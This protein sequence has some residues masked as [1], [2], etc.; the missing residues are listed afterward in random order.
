[1][2]LK[3]KGNKMVCFLLFMIGCVVGVWFM[4]A[5]EVSGSADDR[6]ERW[7]YGRFDK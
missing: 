1:M 6:E 7:F 3:A 4:C 2:K 5:A